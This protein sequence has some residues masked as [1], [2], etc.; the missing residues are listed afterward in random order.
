MKPKERR[1]FRT[2]NCE[3]RAAL[4]LLFSKRLTGGFAWQPQQHIR[5]QLVVHSRQR[6]FN[7]FEW[8]A[9]SSQNSIGWAR[10]LPSRLLNGEPGTDGPDD[11]GHFASVNEVA[12]L[13][14][15]SRV[16]NR[17]GAHLPQAKTLAEE[18]AP[19]ARSDDEKSRVA[20]LKRENDRLKRKIKDLEEENQMLHFEV[21]NRIVLESFEGEGRIRM[22][23][24]LQRRPPDTESTYRVSDTSLVGTPGDITL[25]ES[26]Q[27]T[28]ESM[29][30]DQLDDDDTCPLEPT[31]SFTEALRD[32]SLWLVGL[33]IMQSLSGIVL[34][35]NEELLTKHPVS[36][37]NRRRVFW[38]PTL[39][40]LHRRC[41]RSTF[42]ARRFHSIYIC[43]HLL[44]NHAGW[45]WRQRRQSSQRPGDSRAGPGHAERTDAGAILDPRTEN[46]GLL[47]GDLVLHRFCAS[48]RLSNALSG[49]GC[50]DCIAHDDCL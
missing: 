9:A 14:T 12:N 11:R 18:E 3:R 26:Y 21:A 46:G 13:M 40:R 41:F 39:R 34:A 27:Q 37:S 38:S 16:E 44:S 50:R 48:R 25:E 6:A 32:R 45:R 7:Y 20:Q 4:L 33:L 43:S 2:G 47:V 35:R 1:L 24:Q 23:A 5:H 36:M 8:R 10:R 28:D 49:N 19:V 22:V 30:C 42:F 31:V 15:D 17:N 29:W